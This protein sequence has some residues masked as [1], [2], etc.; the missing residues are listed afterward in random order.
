MHIFRIHSHARACCVFFPSVDNPEW[1]STDRL[2]KMHTST[3]ACQHL[4]CTFP[5]LAPLTTHVCFKIICKKLNVICFIDLF[6]KLFIYLFISYVKAIENR[7]ITLSKKM[8]SAS[9]NSCI[10]FWTVV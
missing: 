10:S 2:R 3:C 7:K 5:L 9:Y 6:I 1:R 4:T 8:K